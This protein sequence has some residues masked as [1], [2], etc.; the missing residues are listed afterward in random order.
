MLAV[1]TRLK[2]EK[3]KKTETQKPYSNPSCFEVTSK[4]VA[5]P[6]CRLSRSQAGPLQKQMQPKQTRLKF[7]KD[8]KPRNHIPTLPA[9]KLLRSWLDWL[10]SGPLIR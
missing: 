6:P 1:Q 8:Q 5:G 7:E 10:A 3:K 4:Q 9:S 2:F